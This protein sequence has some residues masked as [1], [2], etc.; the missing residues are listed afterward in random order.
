SVTYSA[1]S[2]TQSV[3]YG[4]RS[5]DSG[6]ECHLMR[7][8][9]HQEGT[10]RSAPGSFGRHHARR[11]PRAAP[12]RRTRPSLARPGSRG[13]GNILPRVALMAAFLLPALV[14]A[15][16]VAHAAPVVTATIE[17]TNVGTGPNQVSYSGSWTVCGG[18][19]PATPNNSFRYSTAAGASAT[20][21][22]TGTQ[23]KIYGVREPAG[24]LARVSVDGAPSVT[25]NTYLL[26]AAAGL[27]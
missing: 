11:R 20:I 16:A 4:G 19:S 6:Q 1:L 10:R 17:D 23:L 18:C 9:A 8:P 22:F 13:R 14:I 2:I 15:P 27:I 24:G 7:R 25:I 26:P 12:A 3:R 21:H 5:C